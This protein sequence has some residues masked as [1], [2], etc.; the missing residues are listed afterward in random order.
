V[1]SPATLNRSGHHPVVAISVAAT[2]SALLTLRGVTVV[3]AMVS[4]LR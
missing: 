4:Q 3:T 1:S 2:I